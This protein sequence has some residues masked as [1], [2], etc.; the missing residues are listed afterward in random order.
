MLT[1]YIKKNNNNEYKEINKNFKLNVSK[2]IGDTNT[3]YFDVDG[4][5]LPY[6]SD[7]QMFF[8]V[9]FEQNDKGLIESLDYNDGVLKVT[10]RD[11]NIIKNYTY[12]FSL[13]DF[14]KTIKVSV[15]EKVTRSL[16][17]IMSMYREN[18]NS[19]ITTRQ[20]YIWIIYDII[21]RDRIPIIENEDDLRRIFEVYTLD[22]MDILED[23]LKNVRFYDEG[24]PIEFVGRLKEQKINEIRGE[25]LMQMDASMSVFAYHNNASE[26][27]DE[28]LN[29]LYIEPFTFVDEQNSNTDEQIESD[30]KHSVL[31]VTKELIS[32][33]VNSLK[34]TALT[35]KNLLLDKKDDI[36]MRIKK[37]N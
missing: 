8:R 31:N 34:E 15:K 36:L 18:P 6:L 35:N 26:L 20:K 10:F 16:Y 27:Y 12:D 22:K 25:V 4:E 24:R 21:D 33:S 29:N 5:D 14:D 1:Y 37:R 11:G 9:I 2:Y 32:Q 3:L 17:K 28:Y 7:Y 30:E 13:D 23:V 19:Q